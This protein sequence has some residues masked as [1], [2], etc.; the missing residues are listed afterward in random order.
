MTG[1]SGGHEKNAPAKAGAFHSGAGKKT[2][3]SELCCE[4]TI[5]AIATPQGRGGIAAVRI[6]GPSARDVA[7]RFV[8]VKRGPR[9]W[10]SSR[11]SI[12]LGTAVDPDSKRVVDE[13]IVLSMPGPRS[14]T[15]EDVVEVQCHGGRLVT[16]K[17][18]GLALQ[19]GARPACQGEFTRRAYL[20]G[21]ITLDQAEAVLDLVNAPSEASLLEAGRRLRGELGDRIRRLEENILSALAALMAATDFPE[22]VEDQSDDVFLDLERVRAEIRGL[23]SASPLGLALA[24]GIE[25]CLVGRPN[26]GKSSLFN[27]LLGQ[28]RAIVTEVPGTTRDVLREHT[29]WDSLPVTLLDTAGLR[30]TSEVVEAIGVDRAQQAA[31][32]SEVI[33]Y[34]VDATVPLVE[35][36]RSWIERW[37]GRRLLAVANKEDL[38]L[39][40]ACVRELEVLVPGRWVGVSTVTGKGLEQV[41]NAVSRWFAA[42]HP[43][44]A[45]PGSARQVD[46]LR[47][48]ERALSAALERRQTGWTEDVVVLALEEAAGALAELTGKRV[49]EAALEQVFA[50]FCVGK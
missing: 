12:A 23:L 30:E 11:W 44:S 45:L 39:D 8:R 35:E 13:A 28:E 50:R 24:T 49:S 48:A 32:G 34:V 40:A 17:V 37:H 20:S 9:F 19:C 43:E 15:G 10:R 46:C 31:L 4:D 25:V 38:G 47:R 18:L 22:D 6:S 33:L 21:R 29:E 1:L 41:K 42:G 26:A 27:A 14:Y 36:D 16:E 7:Q 2:E 3:D 5:A